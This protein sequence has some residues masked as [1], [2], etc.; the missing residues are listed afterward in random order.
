MI[1]AL[2]L[3]GLLLG[4]LIAAPVGPIG[5]LC[6]RRSL[7]DGK[8]AGFATGL[9]AA[10]ADAVY[11]CVAAC[12]F[13]ALS[14]FLVG[15][16]HW[17]GIGGGLLLCV[18]GVRIFAS[19]PPAEASPEDRRRSLLG[20]WG[21]TFLLT[22]TNPAT[23]L[24][25]AGMFGAYARGVTGIDRASVLVAGVFLGSAAWW[26]CLSSVVSGLRAYIASP[27]IVIINRVSGALLVASG[28]VAMAV[29]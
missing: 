23:I 29:R 15:H 27:R 11:G 18:I 7:N 20:A 14:G 21:S 4:L 17:V 16:R 25:F 2:L 13:T 6:I 1:L 10:S 28:I 3:K 8:A 19:K 22:L 24:S 5:V 26:F 12:G 9:G